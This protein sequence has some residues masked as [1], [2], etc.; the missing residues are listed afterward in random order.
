MTRSN[1]AKP[2]R[3]VKTEDRQAAAQVAAHAATME[4]FVR[5]QQMQ[6]EYLKWLE[7][8]ERSDDLDYYVYKKI[9]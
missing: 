6:E 5:L 4:Q 3:T 9:R 7:A 2:A 8:S 1:R